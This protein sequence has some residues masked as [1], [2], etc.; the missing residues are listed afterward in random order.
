MRGHGDTADHANLTRN[1]AAGRNCFRFSPKKKRPD[2]AGR[3]IPFMPA[4]G[5]YLGSGFGLS[6]SVCR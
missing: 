5:R 3:L 6:A 1:N 4:A 2:N